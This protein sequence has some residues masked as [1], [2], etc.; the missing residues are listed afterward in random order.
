MSILRASRR[1]RRTGSCEL[2]AQA[3]AC[4]CSAVSS[5]LIGDVLMNLVSCVAGCC[6]ARKSARIALVSATE[7]LTSSANRPW[8]PFALFSNTARSLAF[9]AASCEFSEDIQ[10]AGLALQL[11]SASPCSSAFL[12]ASFCAGV[13]GLI[14]KLRSAGDT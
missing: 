10:T 13:S 4:F 11:T 1:D 3:S 12:R 5:A 6:D 7:L 14:E 2:A 9:A 8:S